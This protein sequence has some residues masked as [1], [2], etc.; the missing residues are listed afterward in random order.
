MAVKPH[1]PVRV[2]ARCPTVA[3]SE[4]TIRDFAL[5]IDEPRER[6]GENKGPTPMEILMASFAGCT[7]VILNKICAEKGVHLADVAV[8]ILGQLDRRGIEG[9]ERIAT[10]FPEVRLTVTCTTNA[11]PE[12]M[13]A[14][15]EELAWR[16]PASV[17]LRGQGAAITE[18]WNVTYR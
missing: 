5:T 7:N 18:T 13:K 17:V 12:R 8:D 6:H 14:I 1:V 9:T 11:T 3:R 16:C 4:V 2:A 10:A 15:Q